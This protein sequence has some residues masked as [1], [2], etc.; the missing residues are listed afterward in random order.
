MKDKKYRSFLVTPSFVEARKRKDKHDFSHGRVIPA[1]EAFQTRPKS[2]TANKDEVGHEDGDGRGDGDWTKKQEALRGNSR[3]TVTSAPVSTRSRQGI[4]MAQK[5][6][7]PGSVSKLV[8]IS[9]P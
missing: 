3:G 7:P 5:K 4:E 2:W 8:F 6:A 9:G 1:G